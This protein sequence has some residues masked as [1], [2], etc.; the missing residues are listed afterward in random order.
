PGELLIAGPHVS[1][2][3]WRN[4]EA[5]AE[6]LVD[7]PSGP[8]FRT[9][10]TARR[11]PTGNYTIIGRYKDMIKSGGENVYAAEVEAVFREHPA[12]ADCALIGK[13]DEV[14]GEVGLLVVVFAN[15]D[16]AS[17]QDLLDF[18]TEKLA[19][20]KLPKEIVVTDALPYSP[21]G[22]IEKMKLKEM[23]VE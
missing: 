3:Y 10:D 6:A 12:V 7:G 20:F 23:Y 19:R 14:W 18:C 9:G 11:D 1:T 16:S 8:W 17:P 2:G 15:S 13:P 5:T 21:Y 4:P 22:K